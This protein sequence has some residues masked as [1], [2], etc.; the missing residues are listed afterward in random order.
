MLKTIKLKIPNQI[1]K[2]GGKYPY[3]AFYIRYGL[4]DS[5]KNQDPYFT[6]TCSAKTPRGRF[7]YGGAD[8]ESIL[9]F[10]PDMKDLVNL[11]LSNIRGEPMYAE[12]NGWFILTN[13]ELY[14]NYTEEDRPGL[15]A[16]HFRISSEEAQSLID[17]YRAGNFTREAFNEYVNSQRPRWKKEAQAAIQ[18]YMLEVRTMDMS[19]EEKPKTQGVTLNK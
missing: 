7:L 14:N 2:T 12:E 1:E 5:F 10:R 9:K 19:V 11:H 4:E 16:K 6:I 18:K 15:L 17:K 13:K 3:I 8:H